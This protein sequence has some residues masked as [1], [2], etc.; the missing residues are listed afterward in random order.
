[1][2]TPLTLHQG[3][4]GLEF[5]KKSWNLPSNFPD[6]EGIWNIEV[7][8]GKNG[9]K[10]C[11]FFPKLLQVLYKWN[12][13]CFGQILFNLVR[14]FA[15]HRKKRFVPAFLRSILITYYVDNLESGKR[16]YCFGKKVWNKSWI[17]HPKSSTNPVTSFKYKH[18]HLVSASLP[19]G[20][21]CLKPWMDQ[22]LRLLTLEVPIVTKI[23]FLLTISIHC[24]EICYENK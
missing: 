12:V 23:N 24:Q 6:L 3:S 1:M 20:S 17:L 8:S 5:V 22:K 7:K 19:R 11:V 18:P 13:F 16:N 10:S 4:Y 15:V 9:K 14:T 21:F 2:E